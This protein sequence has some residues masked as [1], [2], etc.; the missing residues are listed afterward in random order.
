MVVKNMD[1][2]L[3]IPSF[4][5][6]CA[7]DLYDAMVSLDLDPYEIIDNELER[8]R[9]ENIVIASFEYKL[10]HALYQHSRD[11]WSIETEKLAGVHIRYN[12]EIPS[13]IVDKIN[14]IAPEYMKF[15]TVSGRNSIRIHVEQP[16]GQVILFD[17]SGSDKY[18]Y[19]L[20][21]DAIDM[22]FYSMFLAANAIYKRRLQKRTFI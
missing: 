12:N 7:K 14:L 21:R 16:I 20:I 13:G 17:P 8:R 9:R 19:Y 18:D 22:K 11:S 1:L 3:L 15:T 6:S 10:V 5:I 2:P 4:N